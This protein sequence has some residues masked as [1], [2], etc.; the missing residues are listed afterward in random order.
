MI[1]DTIFEILVYVCDQS[2]FYR[3]QSDRLAKVVDNCYPNA[4]VPYFSV[5][6]R[7]RLQQ[8]LLQGSLYPVKYNELIGAIEIHAVCTQ[9]RADWYFT[10]SKHVCFSNR[11]KIEWRDKLLEMGT[12]PNQSSV[13]IFLTFRNVLHKAIKANRQL[14]KRFIDFEAFDRCGPHIDWHALCNRAD[15]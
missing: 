6:D 14:R 3:R 1:N 9:I 5:E 15:V 10:K 2:S 7:D 8:K 11:K 13:D 4:L 12:S